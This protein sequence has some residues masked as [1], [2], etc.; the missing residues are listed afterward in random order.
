MIAASRHRRVLVAAFVALLV[1]L[2]PSYAAVAPDGD[3]DG[4]PTLATFGVAP[5]QATS[6]DPRSFV[7]IGAS[8]GATVYENV[9]VLNQSD[10]P[11]TLSVYAS[12]AVNDKTDGS[13]TLANRG[14]L[15]DAGAW[16]E[17]G[18]TSV[19]VPA[20]SPEEGIGKVIV[21]FTAH[22]PADAEPGD[23][24]A[25]VVASLTTTGKGDADAPGLELEQRVGARVYITVA[26]P[27]RPALTVTDVQ[28]TYDPGPVWGLLGQGRTTVTYTLRN[29]GNVRMRVEPGVKV[30]GPFGLLPASTDGAPVDELLPRGEVEQEAVVDGVWPLVRSTVT[31]TARPSTAP[32]GAEITLDPVSVS[33]DLWTVPWLWLLVLLV[34][35]VL[36]TRRRLVALGRWTVG[37]VRAGRPAA[38]R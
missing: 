2:G 10:F 3:D 38:T 14:E 27:T 18:A 17:M 31:V 24:V 9:A 28:A 30:A 22:I 25:A 35:V 33:Q 21:P 13:L 8:P 11:L 4:Q 37:K 1:S 20:Q 29:T 6:P 36:L 34:V 32:D 23:H 7:T 15:A 5:A 12:E 19:D 26:G 16:L